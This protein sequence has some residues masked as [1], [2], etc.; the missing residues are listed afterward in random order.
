MINNKWYTIIFNDVWR[1]ILIWYNEILL[2][3]YII[4]D[5]NNVWY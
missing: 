4:N 1:M 3:K 2:M 5:N